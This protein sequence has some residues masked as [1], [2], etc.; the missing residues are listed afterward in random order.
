MPVLVE[1]LN[2]SV[3]LVRMISTGLAPQPCEIG[4]ATGF[5]FKM[6]EGKFL[7]TNRH[8]IIEEEGHHYPDKLV[9]RVHT[10]ST[11][12]IP[13]RDIQLPLYS[14]EKK[15]LWLQHSDSRIDVA[16]LEIGHLIEDSDRIRFWQPEEFSPAS[17]VIEVGSPVIVIGY[18]LGL[19]DTPHNL[20][21]TRSATVATVYRAHFRDRRL[22]LVDATLHEGTSGSPVIKAAF[23][24][25][26]KSPSGVMH[27]ISSAYLL[28]ANSGPW[29]HGP[30]YAELGLQAVWYPELISEIISQHGQQA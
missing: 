9:I 12:S 26:S 11:S 20:P 1:S 18:P 25:V 21:I 10:S 14:A 8:V 3:T 4:S 30:G 19:Y 6:N 16:V 15:P 13:N 17:E 23:S 2:T 29:L 7:V 24:N 5:F 22:F 28:G 27:Y